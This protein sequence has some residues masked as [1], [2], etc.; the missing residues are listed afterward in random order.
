MPKVPPQ[1]NGPH[2]VRGAPQR[3][4]HG[5]RGPPAQPIINLPIHLGNRFGQPPPRQAVPHPVLVQHFPHQRHP[6]PP[7]PQHAP[8]LD[9][10]MQYQRQIV[11][12]ADRVNRVVANAHAPPLQNQAALGH[13]YAQIAHH[14]DL[15]RLAHQPDH[16]AR[17]IQGRMYNAY[18]PRM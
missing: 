5:N 17:Y 14:A 18:D 11:L 12:E 3:H 16:H 6:D 2:A 7:V 1:P 15:M 9:D 13:H 8:R 10:L 4:A